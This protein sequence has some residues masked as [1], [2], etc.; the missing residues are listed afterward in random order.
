MP[1]IKCSVDGC[2]RRLQPLWKVD[3]R[4]RDTWVYPECD[5]CH[6]PACERHLS[7]DGGGRAVCD[8]CRREAEAARPLLPLGLRRQEGG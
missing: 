3:V 7:Q 4:D 6:C 8:R 1:A 5:V 2:G